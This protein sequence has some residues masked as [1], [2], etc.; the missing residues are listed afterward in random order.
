MPN[1][2]VNRRPIK[3]T[4]LNSNEISY[5][6]SMHCAG[7]LLDICTP[8]IQQVCKKITKK[9]Y[10][11]NKKCYY[12]FEYVDKDSNYDFIKSSGIR[13]R[14]VSDEDKKKHRVEYDTKD[15]QCQKCSK[16]IKNY[17]RFNHIKKCSSQQ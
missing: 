1:S 5:Y 6:Y 10:S 2:L 12:T 3:A 14:K 16:I 9:T 11:K 13:P 4:N 8:S 7:K 17:S 15:W